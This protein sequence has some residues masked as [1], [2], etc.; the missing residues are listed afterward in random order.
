MYSKSSTEPW[1]GNTVVRFF[2][3]HASMRTGN[4][5]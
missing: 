2:A 4:E 5:A 1:L 3:E